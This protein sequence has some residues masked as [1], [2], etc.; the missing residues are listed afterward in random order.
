MQT[1]KWEIRR[2]A[3]GGHLTQNDGVLNRREGQ[4]RAGVIQDS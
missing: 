1:L 3:K 2:K 4:G